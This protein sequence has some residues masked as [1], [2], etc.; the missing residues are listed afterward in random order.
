MKK[1][2]KFLTMFLCTLV[3]T[4]VTAQS[5]NSISINGGVSLNKS[6]SKIDDISSYS[7]L[8]NYSYNSNSNANYEIGI[9]F[10]SFKDSK[11]N[12]NI[13]FTITNL[14]IGYLYTILRNHRNNLIFNIGGGIFG[15]LE[16]INNKTNL[17][18]NSTNGTVLG[19]Y[20]AGQIEWFLSDNFAF[21]L[22]GQYNYY[23]ISST[24]KG[25]PMYLGGIKFLF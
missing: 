23:A 8:I 18:I 16:K 14:Q 17:I 6:Q 3:T 9:N 25:N 13:D 7:G 20:G 19:G 22:R 24:G 11:T 10:N 12:E 15:G 2:N 4:L 1:I 5:N 21:S